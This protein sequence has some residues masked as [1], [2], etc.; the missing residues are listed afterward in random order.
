MV[1]KAI[2]EH[3][4]P[5]RREKPS[6]LIVRQ[7]RALIA[8]GTLPPGSLLP[9]ERDLADQFGVSRSQV[10]EALQ[11]LDFFGVVQTFPQSGTRV[12]S[13]GR[14]ALER[15]ITNILDLDKSDIRALAETRWALEIEAAR[16]AA[17]RGDSEDI[18]R[19]EEIQGNFEL[20]VRAGRSGI[21]Y[22]LA[23]HLA[24]ADTAKNSVMSALIG[25]IAPEI[26]VKAASS[27]KTC[28]SPRS[29]VA[30]EEHATILNAIRA[31]KP[32]EAAA[33]MAVHLKMTGRQFSQSDAPM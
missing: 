23:F 25:M 7:L 26:I 10:R 19:L 8:N 1:K 29:L 6:T 22:D 31:Q 16:H 2:L 28:S 3:I 24:I 20:E 21:E 30:L 17:A 9:P 27:F 12:A 13:L 11:R 4:E 14:E 32:D 15:L 18:A 33:A 5:I